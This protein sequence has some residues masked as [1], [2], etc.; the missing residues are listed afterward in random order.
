MFDMSLVN[1]M[2][3]LYWMWR[4]VV[5]S[6]A[7]LCAIIA[8]Q[9]TQ[10][11]LDLIRVSRRPIPSDNICRVLSLIDLAFFSYSIFFFSRLLG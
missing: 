11:I 4:S 8:P 6:G 9:K 2:V 7:A 1:I 10:K 3:I 5:M